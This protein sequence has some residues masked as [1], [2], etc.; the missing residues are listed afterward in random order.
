M[1]VKWVEFLKLVAPQITSVALLFNPETAPYAQSFY[2]N[3]FSKAAKQI[4][5]HPRLAFAR[6]EAEIETL[7]AR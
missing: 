7:M 3:L 4:G 6:S 1:A 2:D 5:V